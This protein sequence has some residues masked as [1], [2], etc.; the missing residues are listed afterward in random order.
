CADEAATCHHE[1]AGHGHGPVADSEFVVVAVFEFTRRDGS[2][3]REFSF[4]SDQLKRGDFST[5]RRAYISQSDFHTFVIAPRASTE[6]SPV[7]AACAH[8]REIRQIDIP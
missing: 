1:G 5:A 8:V 7:G 6:G 3:L 2:L 4:S